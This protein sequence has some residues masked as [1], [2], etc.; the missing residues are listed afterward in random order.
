MTRT[1]SLII[2]IAATALV[3]G[4]PTAFGE[5]RLA[6]SQEP[7]AVAP[8]WFERAA[9]AAQRDGF[10]VRKPDSHD[11][12]RPVAEGYIDAAARAQRIDIVVPTART[13]AFERSAP[14]LGSPTGST[15]AVGSGSDRDWSQLG[16][17][18]GIGL[19]LALGL[20]LAMRFTRTRPL[21]H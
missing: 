13:D 11:V 14:P 21:A 6:G 20:Y 3:V 17:G 10:I 7:T 9:I 15:E 16:M 8:D 2:G 19:L 12:V 18:F 1:I 5:G 4:V